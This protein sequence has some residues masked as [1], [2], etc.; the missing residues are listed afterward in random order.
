[1]SD[2]TVVQMFHEKTQTPYLWSASNRTLLAYEDVRSLKAKMA[3][4]SS[5][6]IGGVMFWAIDLDDDQMTLLKV[7]RRFLGAK[8]KKPGRNI[9][10][11][12]QVT[13][14]LPFQ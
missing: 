8:K 2:W 4:A 12:F 7:S 10:Q 6:G 11:S 1:M 9:S 14:G 13:P 5:R 3:Y